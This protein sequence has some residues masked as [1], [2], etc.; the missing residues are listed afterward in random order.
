MPSIGLSR[1]YEL[2]PGIVDESLGDDLIRS[3]NGLRFRTFGTHDS[4]CEAL[5]ESLRETH[6]I[7]VEPWFSERSV[8]LGESPRL[9]ASTLDSVRLEPLSVRHTVWLDLGKPI[10]L[11]P[12][13]C[14]KLFYFENRDELRGLLSGSD[15][16]ESMG[17][18]EEHLDTPNG[19]S[20][21][22]PFAVPT[23]RPATGR[24]RTRWT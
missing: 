10:S 4:F 22:M 13:R 18:Y 1:G 23:F 5:H 6:A 12:D 14:S 3:L 21:P 15:E 20:G 7:G 2:Y 24:N 11:E 8:A 19:W 16:P 17:I 9:F